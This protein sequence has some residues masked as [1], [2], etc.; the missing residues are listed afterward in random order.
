MT[1]WR[2]LHTTL[3][4]LLIIA[5]AGS[6]GVLT[7]LD[8]FEVIST[9]S[10]GTGGSISSGGAGG[11]AGEGG[12]GG[13]L[14]PE[15]ENCL[16]GIDND[17]DGLVD[18]ADV[19]DCAPADYACI[20]TPPD[21]WTGNIHALIG[22]FGSTDAPPGCP[23]GTTERDFVA[24]PSDATCT[25]CACSHDTSGASCYAPTVTCYNSANCSAG[26]SSVTY[27]TLTD[28]CTNVSNTPNPLSC[29]LA[30][31]PGVRNRGTCAVSE[32]AQLVDARPW[33]HTVRTC[34][35]SLP[36][37]L[38]CAQ[39][40]HVCA[41]RPPV[42]DGTPAID[43]TTTCILKEGTDACEPGW[44][45]IDLQLYVSGE[46]GRSC[47]ACGCNLDAITCTGGNVQAYDNLDCT[48][49]NRSVSSSGC[50]NI[51]DLRDWDSLGFR[52]TPGTLSGN[53]TC[54]GGEGQGAVV[55]EGPTKL[56]C[57]Q[58]ASLRR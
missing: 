32:G 43:D 38:G 46:D 19:E 25:P 4:L 51:T 9:S 12:G 56:C 13:Q 27:A 52:G 35:S 57:R 34:T 44:T 2:L 8:Q 23:E 3:G 42:V 7:G 5:A 28:Q 45:T 58:V 31:P 53:V 21:G 17:L 37:G 16:D 36:T 6:C 47:A 50:T 20:P 10:T 22:D 29:R 49:D 1:P 33:R 54:T 40:D 15:P 24:E 11:N 48:G 14:Q 39:P 18:C 30:A 26:T 41:A 55:T